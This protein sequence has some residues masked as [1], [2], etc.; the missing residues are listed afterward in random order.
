MGSSSSISESEIPPYLMESVSI[1]GP[2]GGVRGTVTL[3][4]S[5]TAAIL[6]YGKMLNDNIITGY[7][8]LLAQK[9][10]ELGHDIR[11]VPPQF[12]PAFQQHGWSRVQQWVHETRGMAS[13][14]ESAPLIFIPIFTGPSDSGH[15]T[16]CVADR[17]RL[18][19]AT[20]GVVVYEDSLSPAAAQS[21]S[22]ALKKS[23]LG[24][25][26]AKNSETQWIT[27]DAPTQAPGSNACGVHVCDFFAGYA[28]A[29]LNACLYS[30]VDLS[31]ATTVSARMQILGVSAQEWGQIGRRHILE[32][33]R[34]C[35]INLQDP[36]ITSVE[37]RL[38]GN[39]V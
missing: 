24:T 38:Y 19:G 1:P 26:L 10:R 23:L 36:A 21:S 2:N 8:N 37:V 15:Y 32:S 20:G 6:D 30:K 16:G 14:W 39:C 9:C 35:S 27:A 25:P 17:V 11:V 5:D 28:S 13:N 18:S 4:F 31:Q 7:L 33:L 34:S 22:N 12:Y 29:L 3:S